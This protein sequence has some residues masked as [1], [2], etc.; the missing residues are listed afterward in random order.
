MRNWVDWLCGVSVIVEVVD[1]VGSR[2]GATYFL[3]YP[4]YAT[5]GRTFVRSHQGATLQ[6]LLFVQ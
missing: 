1:T 6:Y 3:L 5:F 4:N 2:L